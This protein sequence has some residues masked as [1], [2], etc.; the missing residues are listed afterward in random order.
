M[1]ARPFHA[2]LNIYMPLLTGTDK[3]CI[4]FYQAKNFRAYNRKP[5]IVDCMKMYP[6]LPKI[7][8][9]I[10][11]SPSTSYLLIMS[12][13]KVDRPLRFPPRLQSLFSSLQHSYKGS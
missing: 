7:T 12:L 3:G 9:D 1:S 6:K 10:L 2:Q 5:F 11:S 4:L 8:D 13:G